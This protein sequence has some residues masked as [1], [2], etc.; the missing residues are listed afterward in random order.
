MGQYYKLV[1]KQTGF[2]TFHINRKL[3]AYIPERGSTKVSS[4][5]LC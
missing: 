1:G 3:T 2:N 4:E 5:I